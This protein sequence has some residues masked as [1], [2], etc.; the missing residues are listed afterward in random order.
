MAASVYLLCTGTALICTVLLFRAHRR[1]GAALLLWFGLCFAGLT[2]DNL[3]LFLD[4]IIL[5][6]IDLSPLCD[7]VELISL[8][9]LLY[10]MVW[11]AK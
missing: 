10:G 9:T 1:N 8:S 6:A 7:A 4:R 3:V 11:R 5:P 2:L